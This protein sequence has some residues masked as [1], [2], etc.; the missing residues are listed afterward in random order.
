[1]KNKN[2][3][4][5]DLSWVEFN[6]RVL[7][8]AKKERS[9]LLER[10][11]FLAIVSGNLDQFVMVRVPKL[12][13]K[14]VGNKIYERTL[15]MVK[16]QY[17][18]YQELMDEI[19]DET[20][21]ELLS[22]KELNKKQHSYIDQYFIDQV[23]P[24]LEP[25]ALDE[26]HPLP[27]IAS[28]NIVL[29]VK[30]E[31]KETEK[32]HHALLELKPSLQRVIALPEPNKFIL[33]EELVAHKL[34]QLFIDFRIDEYATL[35]FTRDEEMAILENQTNKEDVLEEVKEEL[36]ERE[37]GEIIRIEYEKRISEHMLEYVMNAIAPKKPELYEIK[38]PLDLTY[39][40]Q[41]QALQGFDQ[42]RY[43]VLQSKMSK[44]LSKDSIFETL[45]KRDFVLLHPYQSF[46]VVTHMIQS[47]AA[48][49]D[50]VAIKQ[51][52]YR[53][54]HHDSP[55]IDALIG[56]CK[57]GK[58]VTVLVELKARFDEGDN[59]NWAQELEKAGA[60]IIYGVKD[61]KVHG[62]TLLIM[63][64]EHG[65]IKR[66]AQLGTGNYYKAPY[67]DISLFT[68]REEL[69]EDV[70]NVFN[71]LCSPQEHYEWKELAVGPKTLEPKFIALIDREI[72]NAKQGI[73]AKII[74]KMNGLT[75][76]TMIE[77]LYEASS[78]GVKITLIVRGPCSLL[79]QVKDVSENIHVYSIVGRFLEHNRVYI[80]ENAANP[81]YYL[82][83]ADWMTRNL[84]HR[85]ELM[86]P[87]VEEKNKA[88]LQTYI[89]MILKDNTKRWEEQNDGSYELVKDDQP[90]FIYQDY[91]LE[92][93]F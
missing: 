41:I 57:N 70:F 89:E 66:Y 27:R 74:A 61:L 77:K 18:M 44:K 9:P 29:V 63:R 33:L 64:K 34:H 22:V 8:E 10:A 28:G 68:A 82:A 43:P 17:E 38:G 7:F 47:A 12:R 50:V 46:E 78:A 53:V 45:K 55:I 91:Y 40:W 62:K 21:I 13:D 24:L 20:G 67:V 60:Q 54:K 6:E 87:I 84:E 30:L 26:L 23:Y 31:H 80:F 88:S 2:L 16:T 37:W 39:L 4:D 35:R 58:Q 72:E 92:N 49:P 90:E 42:Y 79:P 1:M 76:K 52:L 65:K 71:L 11:A 56:A 81:E 73:E 14:K 5:R 3:Y 86:F 83:S 15:K 32:K 75:D 48:D 85:V 19:K 93:K 59:V 69:C 25:I 51:T 36:Q